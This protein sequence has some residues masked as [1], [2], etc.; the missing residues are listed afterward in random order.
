[1]TLLN[2]GSVFFQRTGFT[3]YKALGSSEEYILGPDPQDF[4]LPSPGIYAL[5]GPNQSGKT[6]LIKAL[7][8]VL[9]PA[10]RERGG[11]TEAVVDGRA[12]K[13]RNTADAVKHGV[14]GVFND[15]QLV[16]SM[17]IFMQIKMR[18][19]SP[20]AK[21]WME[22]MLEA[23]RIKLDNMIG[24]SSV[25]Y[26]NL[27]QSL[28]SN[29]PL[30]RVSRW[31]AGLKGGEKPE[32]LEE[33]AEKFI[34]SFNPEFVEILQKYP[35][36]ISTG[37]KAVARITMAMMSP[38]IRLLFLDE[39]L[40]SVEAKTWPIIVDRVKQWQEEHNTAVVVVS[41]NNQELVRWNPCR[42]FMIESK[43]LTVVDKT[44]YTSIAP[45]IP[46]RFDR[47]LVF[48]K[49]YPDNI[50]E[51]T[52]D[53]QMP[54]VCLIV[55]EPVAVTSAFQHLKKFFG[56]KGRGDPRVIRCASSEKQKSFEGY[57]NLAKQIIE[58]DV[59]PTTLVA[60]VGG[61]VLLNL[62][63][64]TVGTVHRGRCPIVLVPTTVMS[65]A[66]VALGSKSA[67]N[68]VDSTLFLK[69]AVGLYHNP[70]AIVL[71]PEY[72]NTLSID[73]CKFGLA[74]CI[75]HGILQ[76]EVL[77]TKCLGLLNG[78][79][80]RQQLFEVAVETMYLKR[81][82]LLNDPF[83]ENFGRLLRFGHLY[84]HALEMASRFTISH[85]S[86]LYW[87]LLVELFASEKTD[88]AIFTRLLANVNAHL[89]DQ[90]TQWA[91]PSLS[92]LEEAFKLSKS[93][94]AL[95]YAALGVP[96]LGFYA[97][98][99]TALD[100][101]TVDL[102]TWDQCKNAIQSVDLQLGVSRPA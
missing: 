24:E 101:T 3:V 88:K 20:G 94:E 52:V 74:E 12:V 65:I 72:L 7:L 71:V 4:R 9:P 38:G 48:E 79:P 84:A 85:G 21:A 17:T 28:G 77:F 46:P 23:G 78:D 43:S 6:I 82:V 42:E 56:E 76:D 91:L 63:L 41:H 97:R 47:T 58:Q 51:L 66:D 102:F 89:K 53:R 90:V 39:A 95:Q 60:I 2:P 96:A 36:E 59:Q 55:D 67:L 30:R 37:A 5:K 13:I 19:A 27:L 18:Y 73:Q 45:I 40:A 44:G 31:M 14:V 83:E 35:Y 54:D 87:G 25:L 34:K 16:S 57:K 1:M 61:G 100:G 50:V 62:G 22:L 11:V 75:K 81:R 64:H 49:K 8:G 92:A 10:L 29:N 86:C 93:H 98:S 80:N 68:F 26:Q 70:I 69:H 15:D 99:V 33:R 32:Y